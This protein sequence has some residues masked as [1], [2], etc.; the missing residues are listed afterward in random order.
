VDDLL[1][2]GTGPALGGALGSPI[3][4]PAVE[5]ESSGPNLKVL[6]GAVGVLGLG[7]VAAVL[8]MVTREPQ[9][10]VVT[11]EVPAAAGT[12]APGAAT[13]TAAPTTVVQGGTE[14]AQP[15][16]VASTAEPEHDSAEETGSSSSR[17]SD[18]DRARRGTTTRD[19]DRASSA[20]TMQAAAASAPS[21]AMSDPAPSTMR[22]GDLDALM[23]QVI[24][25]SAMESTSSAA[26]SSL[27]EQ[28]SR[29]AVRS[30]LGGRA[31]AVR[32][33]GGG[34]GGTAMATVTFSGSGSVSSVSVS[35]VSGSIAGCVS[36]AVRRAHVP[37]FS[38]P[39]FNVT[40]PYRL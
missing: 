6:Y 40:F 15:T 32:A 38:R 12:A 11:Q 9:Q 21:S 25:M 39:S 7:L 14:A 4:A 17:T 1:S 19:R 33:C 20:S 28:P 13:P 18:R 22:S 26:S 27:P 16:E 29:S 3:L 2:I 35:G 34:A 10:I 24:G 8:F 31:S 37:P 30:A 23:G 5:K 36:S